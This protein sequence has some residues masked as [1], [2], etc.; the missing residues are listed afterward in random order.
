MKIHYI[1]SAAILCMVSAYLSSCTK[2][3]EI[4]PNPA[5]Q[6]PGTVLFADSAGVMNAWASIYTGF[7]PSTMNFY[8]GSITIATG[9]TGD[10]LSTSPSA[11]PTDLAVQT[12]NMTAMDGRS[13]ALWSDA[14]SNLFRINSC[15]ENIEGTQVISAKLKNQLIGEAKFTR[16]YTYF[17]LVNLFGGVPIITTT[18]YERNRR[19]PRASVDAVYAQI[20]SDLTDAKRLVMD[21]Y[22]SAGRARPNKMVVNAFLARVYLY[23]GQWNNAEVAATDVI[24]SGVYSMAPLASIFLKDSREAIW[25]LPSNA[26]FAQTGEAF[27]FIPISPTNSRYPNY[28]VSPLMINSFETGDLRKTQWLGSKTVLGNAYIYPAKYKQRTVDGSPAEDYILFRLSEMYFIRAEAFARQEKNT[29]AITDLGRIRNLARVGL[30][31]YSGPVN[32]AAI[33]TAILKERRVEFFCENSHRWY[34]LKRTGTIDQVLGTEKPAFW[35][36]TDA[37]FP[38]PQSQRD[39]NPF[40]TQN[41]GY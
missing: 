12:N 33:I 5:S 23:R 20:M 38:I 24:S 27:N 15:L 17:Y 37:L 6:I 31:P 40:L 9:L 13:T 22:P 10:E 34:D 3:I 32:S 11:F 16:A 39:F 14:Y 21:D 4:P 30:A 1:K 36:S 41:P 28:I 35:Q 7:G 29:D 19:E 18:D 2:L 8:S 25:Q 26:T